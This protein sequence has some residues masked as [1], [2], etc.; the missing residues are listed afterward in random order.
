MG[1]A[2]AI[3]RMSRNVSFI[4]VEG[5]QTALMA[6]AYLGLDIAICAI[7]KIYQLVVKWLRPLDLLPFWY[8]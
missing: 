2:Y 7:A 5:F 6:I 8:P 3:A 4:P 1:H